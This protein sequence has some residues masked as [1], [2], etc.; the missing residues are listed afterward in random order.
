[1]TSE[2]SSNSLI[3]LRGTPC[4][5]N[6]VRCRLAIEELSP[7]DCLQVYLDKGEPEEMVISGLQREGHHV[8]IIQK[9]SSWVKLNIICGIG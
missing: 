8:E 3:D 5:V 9:H 1:M 4:P 7:K 6:F 2:H